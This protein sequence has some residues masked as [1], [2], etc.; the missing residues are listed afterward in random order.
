MLFRSVAGERGDGFA[1][2]VQR[3]ALD[4]DQRVVGALD[5]DAVRDVLEHEQQA[6]LG[7]R[8]HRLADRAAV[9]QVQELLDRIDQAGEELGPLPLGLG[10]VGVF[11]K[12]A[13]VAQQ[14][15]HGR[16]VGLG[17]EPAAVELP[18][19]DEGV[20]EEAEPLVAAVDR[21]RGRERLAGASDK[22]VLSQLA[23]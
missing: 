15:D 18:E 11:G 16:E 9:G 23:D 12:A 14:L 5:R 7:M 22:D 10:E 6:S 3:L 2:T 17:R 20:V 19:L 13:A 8:R 1:Q 4:R 21:D